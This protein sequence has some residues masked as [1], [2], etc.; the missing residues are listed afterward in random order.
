V[1][2]RGRVTRPFDT[3]RRRI[4]I[5]RLTSCGGGYQVVARVKPNARGRFRVTLPKSAVAAL[6]TVRTIVRT[7]VGGRIATVSRPMLI[8]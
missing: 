6:Y 2:I 4:A 3:P 7:K 1:T 5:R 8:D